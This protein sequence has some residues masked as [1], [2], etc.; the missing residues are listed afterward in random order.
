MTN[1]AIKQA[2]SKNICSTLQYSVDIQIH[3]KFTKNAQIHGQQNRQ[4]I[5]AFTLI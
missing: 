4:R 2:I 3:K 5:A 1:P